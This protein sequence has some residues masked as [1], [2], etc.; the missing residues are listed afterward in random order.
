MSGVRVI[1]VF[2]WLVAGFFVSSLRVSRSFDRR[3]V[4]GSMLFVCLFTRLQGALQGWR[5]P[6]LEMQGCIVSPRTRKLGLFPLCRQLFSAEGP[7]RVCDWA[8]CGL[9]L[10]LSWALVPGEASRCL[11]SAAPFPHRGSGGPARVGRRK[12]GVHVSTPPGSHLSARSCGPAAV[13]GPRPSCSGPGASLCRQC[14]AVIPAN[15]SA[16]VTS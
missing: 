6:R 14:S 2:S 13:A 7:G 1:S 16:M 8:A 10:D 5:C 4:L 15:L 9:V 12:R 11:P 3:P